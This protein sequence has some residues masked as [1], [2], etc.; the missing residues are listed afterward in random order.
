MTYVFREC[1]GQGWQRC[2]EDV[3]DHLWTEGY[4]SWKKLRGWRSG[5]KTWNKE[6]Q[7]LLTWVFHIQQRVLV[8]RSLGSDWPRCKQCFRVRPS[9]AVADAESHPRAAHSS[10]LQNQCERTAFV[11]HRRW[12]ERIPPISVVDGCTQGLH[13]H[14]RRLLWTMNL[15]CH[16]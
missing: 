8:S 2:L 5:Q 15:K 10:R 14:I 6:V 4:W 9:A 16:G 11:T 7:D 1:I 13:I 12:W 3:Q